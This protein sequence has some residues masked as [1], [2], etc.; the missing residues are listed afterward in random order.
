MLSC[1][2]KE[3]L[4]NLIK[5]LWGSLLKLQ[6]IRSLCK[7]LPACRRLLFPLLHACNKGN[8]RRLRAGNVNCSLT[9]LFKFFFTNV[10]CYTLWRTKHLSLITLSAGKILG[11]NSH[12]AEKWV[13]SYRVVGKKRA[14]RGL[15]QH[16]VRR[17]LLFTQTTTGKRCW[18]EIP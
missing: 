18:L 5:G 4:E 1:Q 10:I 14:P 3:W 6:I 12:T 13:L 16:P 2:K 17:H 9:T 7:L 15:L 11:G 8:R